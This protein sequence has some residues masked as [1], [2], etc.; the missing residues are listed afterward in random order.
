MNQELPD[1]QAGFR[2][3]RETRDQIADICWIIEKVRKF[4]KNINFCF[5]D[6]AKAFDCVDHKKLWKILKEMGILD[7]LT[8]LLRN[9]YAGQEETELG[10]KQQTGYTL[11]KEYVKAV[12]CHPAYLKH[13][14]DC[15]EKYQ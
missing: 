3:G 6:S 15:W 9:V 7:H 10:I 12:Y 5:I 4:L 11:G 8:Y 1:G 2:K 14:Q 13:N